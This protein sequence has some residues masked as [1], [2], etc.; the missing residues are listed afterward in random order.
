MDAEHLTGQEQ[1]TPT[2]HETTFEVGNSRFQIRA[3]VAPGE[4]LRI[5]IETR[6]SSGSAQITQV[7]PSEASPGTEVRAVPGPSAWQRQRS[8]FSYLKTRLAKRNFQSLENILLTLSLLVYALVHLIRLPDFPIYFFTDEAIQTLLAQNF[9]RDGLRAG[10][11]FFPTYFYNSY[12]YNLGT[13]VYLQVVPYLVL[14]KS[15]W[16]TRGIAALT[17]LL[18]ALWVSLA[19]KKV[20]SIP[21]AWCGALMLS[22]TPAWFLHARTAFETSLA[23]TFYAGFIYYYLRYRNDSPRHIYKAIL[24]AALAFYAYSPMQMVIGI[25]ALLLFFSD[26]KYH[27]QERRIVLK[28]MGVILLCALPFLRFQLAHPAENLHHLQN[29]GSYWVDPLPV[30]EKLGHFF[31][32]YLSGLNPMYW[33]LPN[34]VDL[35]RH[36]MKG[37]GHVLWSTFPLMLVGL[38]T[39]LRNFKQSSHRTLLVSLLAAPSGAALVA[40]GITRALVMV[41]PLAIFSALGLSRFLLW[42]EKRWRP[43]R[44]LLAGGA[45]ILLAGSNFWMLNDALTR[46]PTWYNNYGLDGMQYGAKQV[47]QAISEILKTSPDTHIVLSPSWANGTD[48]VANF[49]FS[50]PLPFEMSGL[51]A[52]TIQR[53]PLDQKTLFI[54]P[55]NEYENLQDSQKFTDIQVERILPYPDRSPGFYFVRARYVDNIDEIFASEK[56]ARSILQEENVAMGKILAHVRYSYLD[57]GPI[58]NVFD[59]NSDTLIRTQEANPLVLEIT[60]NQPQSV[61]AVLVTIGG[62]ATGIVFRA[63]DASGQTF[64]QEQITEAAST[65]RTLEFTIPG[66]FQVK[67]FRLEVKNTYDESPA[68]VHLWDVSLK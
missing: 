23:V 3:E 31:G 61:R 67:Q 20:L 41:I 2:R 14:G 51:E 56:A 63:V 57:M 26:L 60:F 43:N 28:G 9:F 5:T 4:E 19:L 68:H 49:F 46:G 34:N 25:T 37:Y 17:T 33:Y 44:L 38:W 16:V 53:L 32:Q 39:S 8:I 22:L 10:G 54:L 29:L 58:Q 24:C 52:Y 13:S 40:L 45:F 6:S 48:T 1:P 64:T 27:W 21:Y 11:E 50:D 55:T 59:E 62:T 35:P 15:I 47:F 65:L 30:S 42:V 12:Q 7:F 36:L 66:N 18:A